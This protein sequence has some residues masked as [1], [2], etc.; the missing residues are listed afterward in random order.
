MTGLT[1]TWKRGEHYWAEH[2]WGWEGKN[3]MCSTVSN[4]CYQIKQS[5]S[6]T[7]CYK[8]IIDIEIRI[9][10]FVSITKLTEINWLSSTSFSF[11]FLIFK[12]SFVSLIFLFWYSL[13]LSIFPF[14]SHSLFLSCSLLQGTFF[15]CAQNLLS[16]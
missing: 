1:F 6:R 13:F 9:V 10:Q 2:S 8:S 15:L 5:G 12:T 4:G 11:V 14:T 3:V 16:L 7:I